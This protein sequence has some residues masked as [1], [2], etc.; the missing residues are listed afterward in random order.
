[1]NFA[2]AAVPGIV[3]PTGGFDAVA[4]LCSREGVEWK[5]QVRFTMKEVGQRRVHDRRNANL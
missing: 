3:S 5:V 2:V 4:F 1:M